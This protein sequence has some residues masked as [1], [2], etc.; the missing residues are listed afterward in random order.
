MSATNR[1]TRA[2]LWLWW[3]PPAVL[4]ANSLYLRGVLAGSEVSWLSHLL[5]QLVVWSLWLGFTPLILAL[6]RRAPITK[7]PWWRGLAVHAIASVLLSL[8]Y[9]GF[10]SA[11]LCL[12]R[13]QPLTLENLASTY[14]GVFVAVFHW[15]V[16]IYWTILGA[17]YAIEYYNELRR[18]EVREVTL[19]KRLVAAQLASLRAQLQPHFLFNTLHTVGSL[20]R[21]ERGDAALRVLAGLGDLLRSSLQNREGH[22]T[23]LREELDFIRH[24]LD[25][26]RERFE[27]RMR[28]EIVA[29]PE[30][31]DATVPA[32]VLQPLVENAIRHG[33]D[34]SRDAATLKI[35]ASRS[36]GD[37]T[38]EVHNEGP[39]LPDG[40]TFESAAGVGLRNT[41]ERLEQ[42]YEDRAI[43]RLAN[44][45][46]GGVRATVSI[47][48]GAQ[49]GEGAR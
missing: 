3:I 15:D 8:C 27:D 25:I 21:N 45:E 48:Q 11:V 10:Y 18:R 31:L 17:G 44:A 30:T 36:N 13:S 20:I 26:Q 43:L 19:Q 16:L 46:G 49:A 6:G 1:A 5:I 29:P 14:A 12:F 42:L 38:L 28:V 24:Y 47:P 34:R 9:L 40:W 33:F 41:R 22:E 4:S 7:T 35:R 2:L 32:L 23:T 37:L 39:R